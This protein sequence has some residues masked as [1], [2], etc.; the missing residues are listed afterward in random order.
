M[1]NL[2]AIVKY[3]INRVFVMFEGGEYGNSR[4]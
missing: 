1:F 3:S 4:I 2:N